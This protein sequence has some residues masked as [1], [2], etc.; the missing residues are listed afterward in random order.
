[1]AVMLEA[2]F[3]L[4]QQAIPFMKKQNGGKIIHM[5]SLVA[6]KGGGTELAYAVVKSGLCGMTRSMA[7]TLGKWNIT[8][9]AIAPWIT[10]SD[11]TKARFTE[12][13]YKLT[14]QWTLLNRLGEPE[15]IAASRSSPNS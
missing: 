11:L 14:A 4:S 3:D 7:Q 1:M 13:N 10:R 5:S 12:E 2:P 15:D 8:V 6:F 9:N